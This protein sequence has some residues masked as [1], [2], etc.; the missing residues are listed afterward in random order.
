MSEEWAAG[1]M[2]AP[3]GWL[4][5]SFVVTSLLP[6]AMPVLAVHLLLHSGA[7]S[8]HP[9]WAKA[10][11]A[12]TSP[13]WAG[14]GGFVVASV[15]VAAVVHPLSGSLS[16]L[17]EGNW[18]TG[19]L[20][21]LLAGRA[22][23]R[24]RTRRSW[25][26]RQA[27]RRASRRP[28]SPTGE[29]LG[30]QAIAAAVNYPSQAGDV[31]A[32]SLGNALA[33]HQL[34]AG[35]PYNLGLRQLSV[36]IRLAADQRDTVTLDD[37]R[38]RLDLALRLVTMSL[39]TCAIGVGWLWRCGLW[40]LL[41][42]LPYVLAVLLYRGAVTLAA[43][44]GAVLSGVLHLN[45]LELYRRIGL[46]PPAD[47]VQER[48]RNRELMRVLRADEARDQRA[49]VVDLDYTGP[50]QAPTPEGGRDDAEPEPV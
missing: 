19:Q 32:T 7:W 2:P 36:L 31:R 10:W 28:S 27:K 49:A 39:V 14:S 22:V 30:N 33:R 5:R 24:Q 9:D 47:I 40:M 12:L 38:L 18:G 41:T 48:D 35:A 6:S 16:R 15:A 46:P 8:G 25:L 21:T 50:Q 34:E 29:A 1:S 11:S 17:F 26:V 42:V 23:A 20:G 43:D 37:A 13:G 4:G 3:L 44:Y 45:R